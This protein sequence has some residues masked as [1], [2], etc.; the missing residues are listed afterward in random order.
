[1]QS[2]SDSFRG[3]MIDEKWQI[4]FTFEMEIK[5][6][7]KRQLNFHYMKNETIKTIK[8]KLFDE[9]ERCKMNDKIILY[10]WGYAMTN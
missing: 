9:N 8:T 2:N 3:L 4:K 1:M 6:K 5:R 7:T 10:I